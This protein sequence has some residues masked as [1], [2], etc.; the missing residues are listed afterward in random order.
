MVQT[1]G[2][3]TKVYYN[4]FYLHGAGTVMWTKYNWIGLTG[5]ETT[6][7]INGNI[8]I[9]DTSTDG[10]I[11]FPHPNNIM[12]GYYNGV[13]QTLAEYI[14][15]QFTGENA[16]V[17]FVANSAN[18]ATEALALS[19]SKGS[20]YS[21]GGKTKPVYFSNGIPVE[22]DNYPA[23]S[24]YATKT[25]VT[26]KG[27][28]TSIPSEYITETELNS[29]GYLTSIPSEY[30]TEIELNNKNYITSS[31]LPDMELYVLKTTYDAKIVELEAKIAA[32]TPST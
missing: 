10:K 32:L 8:Y 16:P 17:Q 5:G 23:L 11:H 24:D 4:A 30:I 2:D 20:K 9:N 19:Q 29:K 21:V 18:L 28:L 27:Y 12:A 15:R 31:A 13:E 3:G 22:C 26:N 6:T 1:N 14:A 7:Y 25:W